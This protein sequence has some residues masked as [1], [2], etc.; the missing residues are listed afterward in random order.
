MVSPFSIAAAPIATTLLLGALL[1]G[2]SGCA[3]TPG[4]VLDAPPS[5]MYSA[6]TRDM[7]RRGGSAAV[8]E[9]TAGRQEERYAE[10]MRRA[11]AGELKTA[12]EHFYAG[13]ILVRSSE[14]DQLLMAES[15]GRRAAIMGDRRGL[16]VAGE[17]VDRQAMTQDLPQKY[18]TQYSYSPVTGNWQ[19]YRLDPSTTDEQRAETGL[20]PLSWF[21]G[22]VR[23]LNESE[24]SEH[25][26]RELKLPPV[27]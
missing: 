14:M 24:R 15:L 9:A 21:E 19:I 16:P 5:E 23:M 2:T 10:M 6:M 11:E 27:N 22:R 7:D 26:R 4:V 20:P 13:A 12:E 18:G 17:A 3:S 25:L 1:L 8:F